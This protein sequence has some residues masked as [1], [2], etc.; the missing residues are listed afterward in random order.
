MTK[1]KETK[2]GD[3]TKKTVQAVIAIWYEETPQAEKTNES[4][5]EEGFGLVGGYSSDRGHSRHSLA[6]Q[7]GTLRDKTMGV[8]EKGDSEREE[9]EEHNGYNPPL[10]EVRKTVSSG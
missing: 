8:G 9:D 6:W 10:F 4:E 3:G 7:H 2:V 5:D 1:G